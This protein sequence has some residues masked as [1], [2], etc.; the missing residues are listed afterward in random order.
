MH[1]PSASGARAEA[2][3]RGIVVNLARKPQGG[4]RDQLRGVAAG[5]GDVAI[6]NHYYMIL[7]MMMSTMTDTIIYLEMTMIQYNAQNIVG[8]LMYLMTTC[9]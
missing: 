6:A 7:M 2:W 1:W 4:D 9:G 3:A 8:I 5:V